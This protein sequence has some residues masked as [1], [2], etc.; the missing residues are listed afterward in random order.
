M[1][2]DELIK[3]ARDKE[4]KYASCLKPREDGTVIYDSCCNKKLSLV[5]QNLMKH[6][7]SKKHKA[8]CDSK[9]EATEVTQKILNKMKANRKTNDKFQQVTSLTDASTAIRIEMRR[10]Q[11]KS[12]SPRS[13]VEVFANVLNRHSID[14]NISNIS[15]IGDYTSLIQ[16]HE[17]ESL[18]KLFS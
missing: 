8:S 1:T 10:V 7:N 16:S 4:P 17:I 11:M 2:V 14:G 5:F 9:N 13:T 15:H 3:R 6:I 18:V 12:Y